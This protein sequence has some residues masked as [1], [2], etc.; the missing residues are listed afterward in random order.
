MDLSKAFDTFNH[1]LLV[2][3][4]KAYGFDLNAAS[5]ISRALLEIDI[6]AVKLGT[7]LVNG[8]EM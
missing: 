8:R 6:N 2:A 3:K 4:L 5:F 7:R 1:N